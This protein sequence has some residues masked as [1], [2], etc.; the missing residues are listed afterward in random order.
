MIALRAEKIVKNYGATRALDAVDL[1]VHAGKVNVLVGENGAGKS[2]LMK[3][4]AGI[5]RPDSGRLLLDETEI[6]MGSVRKAA[7]Y[8]IRIVHQELSLCPNLSIAENIFLAQRASRRRMRADR[9]AERRKAQELLKRLGQD[10]DPETPVGALRIGQQQIVEIARALAGKTRILIMDEP[11]S[12]LS[13]AE[14]EVLFATIAEL[15]QAGVAIIYISHRLEELFRIGDVV[16]VLRDGCLQATAQIAEVDLEWILEQMLGSSDVSERRTH[17][18][19][20]GEV[21]LS[22]R[23]LTCQR[24]DGVPLVDCVDAD[25]HAGEITALFGL[26]GAGRTELLELLYGARRGSGSVKLKGKELSGLT[27]AARVKQKLLLVPEDRQR[28]GLF[29]NLSV[30]ANISMAYLPKLSRLGIIFQRRERTEVDGMIK[31]IGVRT[32]SSNTPIT[33]LSGGNQQKAV[34]GRCLMPHPAAILLD[35]PTRGIDIGA[36]AEI[37]ETMR[38]LAANGIA[39]LFSSSDIAEVMALADRIL[40]M[41]RG[42]LTDDLLTEQASEAALVRAANAISR[43]PGPAKRS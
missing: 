1:E 17:A 42:R 21:I 24:P 34:I 9:S 38:T 26:L 39:V 11:T 20:K 32:R 3:I 8:G 30:G 27:L 33:S 37:Y 35:E 23:G 7:A 4:L 6:H 22:V 29:Q 31:S 14:V 10:I 40:V 15:K 43:S 18:G 5:E 25:F 36:R 2:T 19:S 41:A 28:E 12:A 13:S 16:T